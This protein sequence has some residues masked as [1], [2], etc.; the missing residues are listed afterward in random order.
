M[1]QPEAWEHLP[2]LLL[3]T[4]GHVSAFVNG[5]VEDWAAD[6]KAPIEEAWEVERVALTVALG[7][8]PPPVVYL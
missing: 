7:V 3:F 1:L 8:P 4:D 6:R 5:A 2:P